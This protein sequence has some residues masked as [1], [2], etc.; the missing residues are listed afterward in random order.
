[1]RKKKYYEDSSTGLKVDNYQFYDRPQLIIQ[2]SIRRQSKLLNIDE[3][4]ARQIMSNRTGIGVAEINNFELGKIPNSYQIQQLIDGLGWSIYFIF[5]ISESAY[6]ETEQIYFDEVGNPHPSPEE[7]RE[8]EELY[9][10]FL[11][12]VSQDEGREKNE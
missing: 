5:G 3:N 4:E 8:F 9:E 12:M 10:E 2:H 6:L 1:M 7:R 11:L